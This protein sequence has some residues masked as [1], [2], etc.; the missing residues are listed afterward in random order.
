[1]VGW[2]YVI[3]EQPPDA[4]HISWNNI[5]QAESVKAMDAAVVFELRT[6][7]DLPPAGL[8]TGDRRSILARQWNF[9]KGIL[10]YRLEGSRADIDLRMDE[11]E[12]IGGIQAAKAKAG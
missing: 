2:L 5:G 8:R 1:M 9:A 7:V 6:I 11:Q 10:E 3:H 4:A 12:L